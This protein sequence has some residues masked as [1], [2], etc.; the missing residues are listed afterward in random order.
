VGVLGAVALGVQT[1]VT[2]AVGVVA[3]AGDVVVEEV[4]PTWLLLVPT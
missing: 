2:E 3:V 4:P 1:E